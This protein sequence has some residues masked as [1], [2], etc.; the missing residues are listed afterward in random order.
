MKLSKEDKKKWNYMLASVNQ[1]D[2]HNCS[3]REFYDDITEWLNKYRSLME[4]KK[5]ILEKYFELL[6]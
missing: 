5:T 4:E 3:K 1:S 6:T 2:K